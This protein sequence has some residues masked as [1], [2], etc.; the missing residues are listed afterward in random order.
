MGGRSHLHP[1]PRRTDAAK[2]L[3]QSPAS[4]RRLETN[5]VGGSQKFPAPLASLARGQPIVDTSMG[6]EETVAYPGVACHAR[7]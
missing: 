3:R 7:G 2:S 4:T 6:W 1:S 5:L